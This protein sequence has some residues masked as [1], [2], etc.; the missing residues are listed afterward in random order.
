MK[1]TRCL[2]R[3]RS[4]AGEKLVGGSGKGRDNCQSLVMEEALLK[5]QSQGVW[6]AY[7]TP[8]LSPTVS[9]SPLVHGSS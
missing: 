9:T 2:V 3:S 1:D 7:L 4:L 6:L 8:C 5:E